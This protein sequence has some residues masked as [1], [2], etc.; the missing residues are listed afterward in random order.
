MGDPDQQGRERC[1]K[2]RCRYLSR[3][4]DVGRIRKGRHKALGV[5]HRYAITQRGQQQE[6][7]PPRRRERN[8]ATAKTHQRDPGEPQHDSQVLVQ[9]WLL[10][11]KSQRNNEQGH[12]GSGGIEDSSDS[13][14]DILLAHRK[15]E[16]WHRVEQ[17]SD[18]RDV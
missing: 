14:G 16:P 17:Q 11:A 8:L 2:R 18:N 13:T 3:S 4:E 10:F 6:R 7:D 15:Q 1:Q 9:C 12:H 5:G